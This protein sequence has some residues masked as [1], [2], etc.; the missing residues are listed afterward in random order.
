MC[1]IAGELRMTSGERASAER[2]RA[3]CDVMVHRGPDSFG[4]F[5]HGEVAL[6]M[7][8]L[9]IVDVAGGRQ[10]LGNED[11]SVQVVCNGEIYNAPAL[12]RELEARGHRLRTRSDVEVIAHLYEEHGIDLARHLDGMFAFA[13]WDGRAHRLVLGRDRVGIKPL[14]VAERGGRLLWGSEA[15]CLVA[16]GVEPELDTQALHDY[17]TLGYVAGPA[18]IFAGVSQ[19][20]PG[21]ILVAE[22]GRGT[23]RIERYWR[24]EGRVPDVRSG[25]PRTEAQWEAEL[26]R[27][28]RGA[29]ES[30][31]MSDVPLGVFLSGGVDSGTIV[32]LMH[33]LGVAPI[34]TFTIG[35]EEKSFSE[36]DGARAVATRYGT[37]HHELVV[38]PDAIALLPTLV[39]HFDEPFADS[40]AIP[41]YY[42]SELARRHVTVVLSGEGGDEMLAGYETYRARRI[43]AAYARLPRFVGSGLVPAIVRRLPVS[44]AKVSFDYKAKRFVTGAY[45]SPAAGHLWWK[46]ILAE[47][48][49]RGLYAA[50]IAAEALPT[51]R[52][53]EAL[54]AQS[55]GGDLDRL[56]YVDTALYLPADILVKVDR[57]SMAHSLEARVP[58]LDRSMVELARRIPARLRLRGLT[59]KYLLKRAMAARLPA[60]VVGGRKRGFNVPMP[61][62]LAGDLREFM[63][64][65]LAPARVRAQ[66]LFDPRA[67]TRLVDEHVGHLADHSR[68][69]W[70]LLV[71]SAWMDDMLGV[72]RPAAARAARASG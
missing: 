19:L 6:G 24:L 15:K 14:Y 51:A 57:M 61:A 54:Y 30:H 10:P 29:V 47:D 35:F 46:T 4:E 66:G 58:F 11:G 59:T 22:P 1:G 13:L 60:A 41:V 49:K 27:T 8:R 36:I 17:L 28:L 3:M 44:H 23:P 42:V 31:L 67:V 53:F 68:A 69:L 43:A 37:E 33:E 72:A 52:L 64:D 18:S 62:W 25:L 45:L 9:A 2:V 63:R 12:M 40:S 34:R 20:P 70:T 38:R 5:A 21:T 50:G 55:D 56:Q 71:L 16:G 48:V 26:V 65:T 7:R 32:A 39:R